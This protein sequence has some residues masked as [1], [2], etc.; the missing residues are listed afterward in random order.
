MGKTYKRNGGF[1]KDRRD[2]NFKQSKKFK[3][4]DESPHH[5][6]KIN[7]TNPPPPETENPIDF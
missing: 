2:N 5:Q 6:H 4:W 7:P 1:K 3:H